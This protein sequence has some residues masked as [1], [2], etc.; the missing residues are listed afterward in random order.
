MKNITRSGVLLLIL[1]L[2]PMLMGLTILGGYGFLK[3]TGG[4]MTGNIAISKN[5]PTVDLV[6]T[7]APQITLDA[8]PGGGQSSQIHQ[9]GNFL[10]FSQTNVADRFTV[11]ITNGAFGLT[12]PLS[13]GLAAATGY[14]RI[15]PNMQIQTGAP[16]AATAITTACTTIPMTGTYHVP[17][18]AKAITAHISLTLQTGTAI[19]LQS[20]QANFFSDAGCTTALGGTQVSSSKNLYNLDNYITAGQYNPAVPATVFLYSNGAAN[21]YA[22]KVESLTTGGASTAFFLEV[23]IIYD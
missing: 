8:T 3:L 15:A 20:V 21:I 6:G 14:T 22:K 18:T 19:G 16:P 2:W 9:A 7:G 12:G 23:P 13:S 1:S 11:D 5:S 10:T 4:T 17:A